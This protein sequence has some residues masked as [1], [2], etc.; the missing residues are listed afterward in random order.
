[1][2]CNTDPE[3]RKMKV[4]KWEKILITNCLFLKKVNLRS[5]EK[6]EPKDETKFLKERQCSSG[7]NTDYKAR[8]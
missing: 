5:Q 1:M 2:H 4:N 7:S 3:Q 6:G 8:N